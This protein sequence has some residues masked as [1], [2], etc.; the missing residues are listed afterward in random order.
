MHPQGIEMPHATISGDTN[1]NRYHYTL[2]D[3]W[4]P[5]RVNTPGNPQLH[6]QYQPNQT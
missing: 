5:A 3:D 4:T 6:I 1:E 2:A